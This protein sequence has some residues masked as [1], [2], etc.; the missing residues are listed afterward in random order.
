M[1]TGLLLLAIVAIHLAQADSELL[2]VLDNVKIGRSL[3]DSIKF[4]AAD[5]LSR[6]QAKS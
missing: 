4:V 2:F 3:P 5:T 6:L 1:G